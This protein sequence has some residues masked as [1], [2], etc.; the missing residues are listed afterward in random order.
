VLNV[1]ETAFARA[2][3]TPAINLIEVAATEKLNKWV[4]KCY[5]R[6]GGCIDL[7]LLEL[8]HYTSADC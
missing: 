7:D 1:D 5:E 3:S 8:L 4:H 2:N 6:S